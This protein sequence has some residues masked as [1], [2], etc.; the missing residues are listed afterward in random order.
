MY[1]GC[2]ILVLDSKAIW[3]RA[4]WAQFQQDTLALRSPLPLGIY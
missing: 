1:V 3:S 4:A 2:K